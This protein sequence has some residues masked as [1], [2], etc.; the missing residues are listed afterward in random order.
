VTGE[1]SFAGL[2]PATYRVDA[3]A[4]GFKKLTIEHVTA[5]V[6]VTT[7]VPVR[8]E[9][10]EVSQTVTVSSTPDALQTADATLGNDFDGKRTEARQALPTI[11]PPLKR[12]RHGRCGPDTRATSP[13]R[14]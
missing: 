11:D 6:N 10:G 7:E 3:E 14:V 12:F 1:F 9:L 2:P 8:L 5:T 4:P 13:G